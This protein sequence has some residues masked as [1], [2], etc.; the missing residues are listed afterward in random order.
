[1]RNTGWLRAATIVLALVHTFPARKHLAAFVD[2]PS[3]TEGWEGFG[4]LVAIALY[5]LPVRTQA[6]ALGALWREHRGA[7]RVLTFLLALVHAVPAADH[8][9]RF[10]ALFDWAD[11]WRGLGSAAAV[12]WF[13]APAPWQARVVVASSR[14][15]TD[16]SELVCRQFAVSRSE[17]D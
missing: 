12:L 9:P 3:F 7:L 10:L 4:A 1:M 8:L 15:C 17:I 11:G 13:L 5:L 16:A 14:A 6:R 2:R